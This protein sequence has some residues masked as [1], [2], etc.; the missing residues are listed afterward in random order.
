MDKNNCDVI[1]S[2]GGLIWRDSPN[3]KELAVIFRN[4]YHDWTLPKGKLESDECWKDA[5]IREAWEETG[6]KVEITGFAGSISYT[7]REM[8]KIVLYWNMKLIGENQFQPN[9]EVD[10]LRWLKANDAMLILSHT[11]ERELVQKNLDS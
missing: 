3:G 11:S 8:P 9:D 4:R 6:C 5:A 10:Q 1:Q 2:S 7:H